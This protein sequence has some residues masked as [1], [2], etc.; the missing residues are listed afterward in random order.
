MVGSAY[1]HQG[2]AAPLCCALERSDEWKY[3][4]H[5]GEHYCYSMLHSLLL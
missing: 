1:L 4:E 2:L 3:V 5:G